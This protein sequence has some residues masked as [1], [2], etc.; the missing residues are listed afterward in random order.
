MAFSPLEDVEQKRM[1]T[2]REISLA[3]KHMESK[4]Y[5]CLCT[6]ATVHGVE[7]VTAKGTGILLRYNPK[8]GHGIVLTAFHVSHSSYQPLFATFTYDDDEEEALTASSLSYYLIPMSDTVPGSR[9]PEFDSDYIFME[10][11]PVR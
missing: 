7:T 2:K 3:Y 5:P 1:L 10:M 4:S 6:K 11:R 8:T 9:S